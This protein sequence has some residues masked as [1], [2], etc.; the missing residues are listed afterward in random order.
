MRKE[1]IV[2]GI[3]VLVIA[4]Y[5]LFPTIK[6]VV[7]VSPTPTPE[8]SIDTSDWK[9]YTNEEYG[10]SIR[11]PEWM[12]IQHEASKN[13]DGSILLLLLEVKS[14]WENTPTFIEGAMSISITLEKSD[15]SADDLIIQKH[16]NIVSANDVIIND[17]NARKFIVEKNST[18]ENTAYVLTRGNNEYYIVRG[19]AGAFEGSESVFTGL[20]FSEY[21]TTIAESLSFAQE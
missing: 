13:L 18:Y 21:I 5:F 11:Y 12:T 10:F 6:G 8:D 20:V 4:G 17:L 16:V 2:V 9:T 1:L 19:S 7:S 14:V 3:V 15:L